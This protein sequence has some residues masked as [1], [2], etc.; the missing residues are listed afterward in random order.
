MCAPTWTDWALLTSLV[1]AVLATYR[2]AQLVAYDDGPF[3]LLARARG[4]TAYA[5]NG[6]PRTGAIW[7]S[8]AG[9]VECP[10]CLGVWF[11]G[12]FTLVAGRGLALDVWTAVLFW[13]AVAGGQCFL[14]SLSP[15]RDQ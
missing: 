2:M 12:V 8:L 6:N 4:L 10:Y 11:A 7:H 13:L 14:Q 15:G 1:L 9:L 5:P 3:D